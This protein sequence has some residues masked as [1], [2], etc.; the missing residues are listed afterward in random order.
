MELFLTVT[1]SV[2]I[3]GT[4]VMVLLVRSSRSNHASPFPG[5]SFSSDTAE[6]DTIDVGDQP[7]DEDLRLQLRLL[8]QRLRKSDA[9]IRQLRFL[10]VKLR[11]DSTRQLV[12]ANKASLMRDVELRREMEPARRAGLGQAI[13]RAATLS[14]SDGRQPARTS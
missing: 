9:E 7:G 8:Q 13:G 1:T 11:E 2:A 3:V 10:Y 6:F 12:E 5:L 4:V 14:L